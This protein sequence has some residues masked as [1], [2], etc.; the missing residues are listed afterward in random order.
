MCY[1]CL[2]LVPYLH[3]LRHHPS[4]SENGLQ[5][6]GPIGA[7]SVDRSSSSKSTQQPNTQS[8]LHHGHQRCQIFAK[9]NESQHH[10]VR[11]SRRGRHHHFHIHF[12]HHHYVHDRR[13]R[14]HCANGS[15]E[16]FTDSCD[17][18]L[19][20]LWLPS[21]SVPN[22]LSEQKGSPY[23]LNDSYFRPSSEGCLK[24]TTTTDTTI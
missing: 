22:R 5:V 10:S 8:N 9:L 3:A 20:A 11:C 4:S 24:K 13:D 2:G 6:I 14:L 18:H 7:K 21:L 23:R 12:H 19:I 16:R 1:V 17:H 15:P